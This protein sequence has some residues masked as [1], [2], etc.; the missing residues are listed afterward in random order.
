MQNSADF[1][2]PLPGVM[3][4]EVAAH[5]KIAASTLCKM[6]LSGDGPPFLKLGLRRVVY[7]VADL[8]RW[9]S[10]QRRRSTFL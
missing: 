5:L 2:S 10:E 9:A 4:K 3:M 7:D 1:S 6:R 8:E